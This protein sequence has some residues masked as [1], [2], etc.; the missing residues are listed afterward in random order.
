[1]LKNLRDFMYMRELSSEQVAAEIGCSKAMFETKLSGAVPFALEEA[2]SIR[3]KF[4]PGSALEGPFGVFESDGYALSGRTGHCHPVMT[5]PNDIFD[6]LAILRVDADESA[7]EALGRWKAE[8][9][10]GPMDPDG[11]VL[12]DLRYVNLWVGLLGIAAESS[13]GSAESLKQLM[14]DSLTVAFIASRLY[15]RVRSEFDGGV[16]DEGQSSPRFKTSDDCRGAGSHE[17]V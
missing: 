9:R 13:D 12:A 14:Y 7:A 5:H 2:K 11:P 17:R 3:D 10:Y 8:G 1:M 4:F 15:E 16:R 6:P